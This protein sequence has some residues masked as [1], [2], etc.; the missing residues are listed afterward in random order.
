[1]ARRAV[2]IE[3]FMTALENVSGDRERHELPG[4]VSNL[5]GI[6]IAV[7]PK[8]AACHCSIH[9]V[10]GRACVGKEVAFGQRT[11]VGLKVHVEAARRCNADQHHCGRQIYAQVS[12]NLGRHL[13]DRPG[14]E[15]SQELAGPGEQPRIDRVDRAAV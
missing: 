14:G 10:A 3:T 2:N 7:F 8:V 15:P 13:R 6:K 9:R 12:H 11:I 4:I 1:M 5:A